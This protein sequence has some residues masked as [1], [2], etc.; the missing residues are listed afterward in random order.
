MR[1]ALLSIPRIYSA[2]ARLAGGDARLLYAR[3]HLR[4][5]PGERVLDIGC[6]PADILEVLPDGCEYYGFDADP[7][8]IEA[9]RSRFGAR[10]HFECRI[11]TAQDFAGYE[12]FDLVMANGVLHHLDD[13]A[14]EGLFHLAHKALGP[15]GRLVTLDGCFV[16]GQSPVA[17]FLLSRDRGQ[18]VRTEVEYLRLA[19][20]VFPHTV[21]VVRSDLMRI[22]Y[23]HVILECQA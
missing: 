8:Y 11:V 2:F 13:G 7:G 3:E 4:I 6:G 12:G 5:Q 16:P 20:R 19:H 21:S 9:A 22:P 23:T 15:R 14:A 10:G 17:R 1:A 18:H